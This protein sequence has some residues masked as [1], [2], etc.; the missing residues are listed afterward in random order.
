[1]GGFHGGLAGS[2]LRGGGGRFAGGGFR[3]GRGYRGYG[4]GG[5][6]DYG[7]DGFGLAGGLLA[8]S[9]IGAGLGYDYGY[10]P[11]YDNNSYA[12]ASGP[13][14]DSG[15]C[16]QRYKSYDPASGNISDMTAFDIPVSNRYQDASK[17]RTER[18]R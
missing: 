6:Y 2:G 3:G 10:D 12:Y 13:I 8:G 14:A 5:G 11:G 16:M 7:D 15:Y 18:A 1:M 9:L 17:P 4:Y